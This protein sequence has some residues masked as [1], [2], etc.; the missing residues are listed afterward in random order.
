MQAYLA[1]LTFALVASPCSTPVLATLL[2]Y[3]SATQDPFLGGALLITYTT[4]CVVNPNCEDICQPFLR[5]VICACCRYVS[6]LLVAATFAGA[7]KQV[8]ALR[9]W[10]GWVTPASGV[11]LLGGGTYGLLTRVV[12]A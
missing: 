8:M 4:G 5:M 6:P 9:Q 2:A 10:S 1:G 7:L 3:V 11:L 12:P